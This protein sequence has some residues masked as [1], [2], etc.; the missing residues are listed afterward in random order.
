MLWR[1][2]I[3]KIYLWGKSKKNNTQTHTPEVGGPKPLWLPNREIVSFR[4]CVRAWSVCRDAWLFSSFFCSSPRLGI[5]YFFV[6]YVFLSLDYVF[7][8]LLRIFVF[9]FFFVGIMYLF[10]CCVQ[11]SDMLW[12]V[13]VARGHRVLLVVVCCCSSL[14]LSLCGDIVWA[15]S[16]NQKKKT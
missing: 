15:E 14:S 1:I 12:G 16:R 4:S 6:F 8:C 11:R 10:F 7:V 2:P 9:F 3:A 13:C 5:M